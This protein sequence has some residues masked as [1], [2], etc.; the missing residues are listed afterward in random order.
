MKQAT[1]TLFATIALA[2]FSF[3]GPAGKAPT[4]KGPMPAPSAPTCN[5]FEPGG[6]FSLYAA[7]F[8]GAD[9][10]DDSL[11]AGLA[12]DYFFTRNLGVEGDA[13]WGF[14]DSTIHTV[15]ASAV[16]RFPITSA[17]IAPYVLAGGGIH[18]DGV[19]EGT[20]HV[21]GGLDVRLKDCFG[22]FADARYTFAQET[23][24]YT[25][26]RAGVRMNF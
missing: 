12:A 10:I 7:A 3:A 14:A 24:D 26:I 8:V 13:T 11:G 20:F 9:D 21:G 22:I 2:G 18:T 17:C 15:N 5:C 1:T 19:T 4:G 6:Q 25:V 16:L 23:D